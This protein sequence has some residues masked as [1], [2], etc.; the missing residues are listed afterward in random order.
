MSQYDLH[1]AEEDR[2]LA[3]LHVVRCKAPRVRSDAARFYVEEMAQAAC[4]GLI[5]TRQGSE[6]GSQWLVTA[7]GMRLVETKPTPK[8]RRIE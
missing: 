8:K 6:W 1:P 2:L 5:T 4:Q 3:L 7:A